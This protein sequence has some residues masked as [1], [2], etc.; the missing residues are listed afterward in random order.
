MPDTPS[1]THD[2]RRVS[3]VANAIGYAMFGPDRPHI[4]V[5]GVDGIDVT[6]DETQR[7]VAAARR[8]LDDLAEFDTGL[9]AGRAFLET[10]A[11][12]QAAPVRVR[13]G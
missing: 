6:D 11:Q 9:E 1:I 13:T 5:D 4:T 12:R 8:V 3:V 7:C 2:E 10:L